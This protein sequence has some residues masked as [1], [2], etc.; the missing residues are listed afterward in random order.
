[1]P[2]KIVNQPMELEGLQAHSD[3]VNGFWD[4]FEARHQTQIEEH[5]WKLKYYIALAFAEGV[6]K[7]LQYGKTKEN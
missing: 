2:R 5:P 6:A 1:M 7:G 4:E 3:L